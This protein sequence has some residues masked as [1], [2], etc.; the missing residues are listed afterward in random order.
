MTDAAR[1]ETTQLRKRRDV[2][3]TYASDR[4][5]VTWEPR[6]CVHVGECFQGLP[7]VFD[8]WARERGEYYA[9]EWRPRRGAEADAAF[10]R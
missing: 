2:S 10:G 7:D 6:L 9:L 1:D 4:I 5:E 3:R 8:P